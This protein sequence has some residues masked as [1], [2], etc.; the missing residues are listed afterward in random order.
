MGKGIFT[1]PPKNILDLSSEIGTWLPET[2]ITTGETSVII[3]S[4]LITTSS[5]ID[6]YYSDTSI[7]VTEVVDDGLLTITLDAALET[8]LIIRCKVVNL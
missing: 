4:P 3:E 1:T 7:S 5:V 8:D 6:I 2:I